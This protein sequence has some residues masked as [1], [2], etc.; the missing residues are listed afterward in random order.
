[1]ALGSDASAANDA[2]FRN[3]KIAFENYL[4]AK[5]I[6][7]AVPLEYEWYQRKPDI[8]LGLR[9]IE[10]SLSLDPGNK[11]AWNTKALLL[12]YS[13]RGLPVARVCFQ[14]ALDIEP[15]CIDTQLLIDRA[16]AIDFRYRVYP[17]ITTVVVLLG[18]PL[19]V[20]WAN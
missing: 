7:D 13:R 9:Y 10:R 17:I 8:A 18:A 1:M 19:L 2:A 20:W 4:S 3:H 16:G 14:K 15:G 5:N 6:S 12:L 11:D